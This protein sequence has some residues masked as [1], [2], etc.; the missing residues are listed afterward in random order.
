M[1]TEL[2][3]LR[4]VLFKL[5]GDRIINFSFDGKTLRL[6]IESPLAGLLLPEST[7]LNLVLN[8]CTRIFYLSYTQTLE[9]R[10][11]Q[12]NPTAIMKKG[13]MIQGVELKLPQEFI[14]YCNSYL[15]TVEA[16]E[17]HVFTT[18]FQLYDQEFGRISWPVFERMALKADRY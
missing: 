14:I 6:E 11:E 7:H 8:T 3:K 12:T 13:L 10:V 15:N 4:E 16:G 9:T 5:Q 2:E 17:L 1:A 18:G